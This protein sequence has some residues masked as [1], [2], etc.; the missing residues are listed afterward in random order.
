MNLRSTFFE[1]W[2]NRFVYFGVL[3]RNLGY[4]GS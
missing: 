1:L 2:Q 4:V 3:I